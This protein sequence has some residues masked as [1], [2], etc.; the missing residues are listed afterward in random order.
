MTDCQ[1]IIFTRAINL[2]VSNDTKYTYKKC[3]IFLFQSVKFYPIAHLR[4]D[5]DYR[6]LHNFR[7][8]HLP[9]EHEYNR[10]QRGHQHLAYVQMNYII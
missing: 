2:I 3:F 1:V 5:I 4:N 8:I 10:F 7:Q 6:G 9:N